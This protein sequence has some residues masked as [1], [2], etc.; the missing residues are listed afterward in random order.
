LQGK[1]NFVP[2]LFDLVQCFKPKLTLLEEHLGKGELHHFTRM[3]ELMAE[4]KIQDFTKFIKQVSLLKQSIEKRFPIFERILR[5]CSFS[6][7]FSILSIEVAV[8][9]A[10]LQVEVL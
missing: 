1:T 9:A 5:M 8:Y 3:P 2:N 10:H 4:T 7:P 6:Y